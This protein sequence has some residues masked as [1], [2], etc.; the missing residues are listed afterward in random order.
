L[1]QSCGLRR[2]ELPNMELAHIDRKRGVINLR[3]AKGKKDRIVPISQRLLDML[4]EYYKA[5]KPSKYLFEGVKEGEQY[6]EK[7]LEK[8]LKQ[9]TRK[10]NI[11]KPVTLHWLRHSY[12][13]T[14]WN[15]AHT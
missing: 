11:E 3:Q 9:S 4:T 14:Y 5:Y 10:A 1:I 15:Q 8:V 6:S 13:T 12:A 7:S 2:S